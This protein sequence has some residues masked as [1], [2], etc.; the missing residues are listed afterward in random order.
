MSPSI[1]SL[2]DHHESECIKSIFYEINYSKF[3]VK[4]NFDMILTL[5]AVLNWDSA[6]SIQFIDI[7]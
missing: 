6:A 2:S 7:A 5:S 1:Y 4:L 3:P